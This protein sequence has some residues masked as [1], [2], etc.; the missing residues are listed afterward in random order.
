MI[1]QHYACSV[2][3]SH[4]IVND[5]ILQEIDWI[6]DDPRLFTLIYRDLSKHYKKSRRGRPSIPVEVTLRM[7]VLR[8]YKDWTYRE[9]EQEVDNSASY[10]WWTRVYITAL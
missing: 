1:I 4:P 8:R 10:R 9:V 3:G 2:K 5:P 6:L 7:I